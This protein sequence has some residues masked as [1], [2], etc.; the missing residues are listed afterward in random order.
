MRQT[1][2]R[3][4]ADSFS[5]SRREN[6]INLGHVGATVHKRQGQS[7]HA[8][9]G[10]C[11]R[12]IL[13]DIHNAHTS[14]EQHKSKAHQ[15]YRFWPCQCQQVWFFYLRPV[16]PLVFLSN[17]RS[18]QERRHL[19]P[20]LFP[21]SSSTRSGRTRNEVLGLL[22]TSLL[23]SHAQGPEQSP[24]AQPNDLCYAGVLLGVG[25]TFLPPCSKIGEIS[26]RCKPST[27]ESRPPSCSRSSQQRPHGGA[28]PLRNEAELAGLVVTSSG[29]TPQSPWSR[30]R[31]QQR[32]S[33]GLPDP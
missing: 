31:R 4:Y 23:S 1:G 15:T 18:C 22:L 5:I 32:D 9:K 3:A 6:P 10:R 28:P 11:F 21:C 19:L 14:V 17:G 2:F 27:P 7:A 12:D 25:E 30:S 16:L 20:V 24:W 13:K 29:V 26:H 8:S 33:V